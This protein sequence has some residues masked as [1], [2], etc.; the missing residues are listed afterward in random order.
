MSTPTAIKRLETL[1]RILQAGRDATNTMQSD[2][3][4]GMQVGLDLALEH[5]DCEIRW[6]KQLDAALAEAQP[7]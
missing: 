2:H 4:R 7:Q 3:A 6:A 5:I 1:R